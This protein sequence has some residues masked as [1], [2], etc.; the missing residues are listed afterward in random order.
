MD[1]GKLFQSYLTKYEWWDK[2]SLAQYQEKELNLIIRFF[3]NILKEPNDKI[4]EKGKFYCA[5]HLIRMVPYQA[6]KNILRAKRAVKCADEL[7]SD[8]SN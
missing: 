6:Q 1:L 7:L 2:D 8:L 4:I 5:V 3:A